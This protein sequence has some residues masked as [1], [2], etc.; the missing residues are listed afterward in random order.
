MEGGWRM[1]KRMEGEGRREEGGGGFRRGREREG[2]EERREGEE[3]RGGGKGEGRG[4][5]REGRDVSSK[6]LRKARVS[7][8]CAAV[9]ACW[10]A[11]E[12][13]EGGGRMKEE[14]DERRREELCGSECAVCPNTRC[15]VVRD[16]VQKRTTDRKERRGREDE[17]E[18]GLEGER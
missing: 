16:Q 18:R 17:R 3:G 9:S 4:R 13:A 10:Y 7:A 2:R 5:E 1:R 14:A 6:R 15:C 11:C 8:F 12:R